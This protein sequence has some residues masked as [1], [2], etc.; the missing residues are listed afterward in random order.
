M[1]F[2][3][4]HLTGLGRGA[5]IV[6]FGR[7]YTA[8]I[9]AFESIPTL[10]LKFWLS[11]GRIIMVSASHKTTK[12]YLFNRMRHAVVFNLAIVMRGHNDFSKHRVHSGR[13]IQPTTKKAN[14]CFLCLKWLNIDEIYSCSSIWCLWEFWQKRLV[15]WAKFSKK[16]LIFSKIRCVDVVGVGATLDPI[17]HVPNL[18]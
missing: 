14:G 6:A 2:D 11:V 18:F 9:V 8:T 16:L 17:H 3:T 4:T 13:H 12:N 15:L 10:L 1:C 7:G 5:T